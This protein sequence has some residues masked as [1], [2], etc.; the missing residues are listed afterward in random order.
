M[1]LVD[2]VARL[3]PFAYSVTGSGSD[4]A[5]TAMQRE[6]DFAVFEYASGRELNGWLIQIGRA[7]V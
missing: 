3:Y 5:V 4:A 1:S 2:L 6:L 7:H